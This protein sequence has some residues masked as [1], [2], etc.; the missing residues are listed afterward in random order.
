M[1]RKESLNIIT[2]SVEWLWVS[3]DDAD[4]VPV[5]RILIDK[6]FSQ[7]AIYMLAKENLNIG[8]LR[9]LITGRNEQE[10]VNPSLLS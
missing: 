9:E 6:I 5:D 10:L 8:S 1:M 2:F 3:K 7:Q 4:I